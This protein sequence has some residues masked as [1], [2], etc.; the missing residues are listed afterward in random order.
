LLTGGEGGLRVWDVRSGALL[1]TTS[2]PRDDRERRYDLSHHAR[3]VAFSPD[4]KYLVGGYR[5]H[6]MRL[7]DADTG[8]LVRTFEGHREEIGAVS[9]SSDGRF[10][11]SASRIGLQDVDILMW[12]VGSGALVRRFSIDNFQTPSIRNSYSPGSIRF[13]NDG[14]FLFGKS[15]TSK[16]IIWD[17]KTG[18]VIRRF[19]CSAISSDFRRIVVRGSEAVFDIRDIDTGASVRKI[20][21]IGALSGAVKFSPGG[22]L[23]ATVDAGFAI[24]VW[25]VEDGTLLRTFLPAQVPIKAVACAR[26][27]R[28]IVTGNATGL[29]VWSQGRLS[30]SIPSN[31][32]ITSVAWSGDDSAVVAGRADRKI[33]F[34]DAS[35]GGTLRLFELTGRGEGVTS[36]SLSPNGGEVLGANECP[37]SDD[38]RL[39][40]RFEK[41]GSGSSGVE[42]RLPAADAASGDLRWCRA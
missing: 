9:F 27:G 1:V 6:K 2:I 33:G 36:V 24:S 3:T 39:I 16:C 32:P 34:W 10:L 42:V 30:M 4:G 35:T 19:E 7:R 11:V 38:L 37:S 14:R 21:P 12:D 18:S 23:I 29:Q 31:S 15:L 22:G 25:R 26:D 5:D 41:G 28:R 13:S 17:V 8:A 40:G 20:A